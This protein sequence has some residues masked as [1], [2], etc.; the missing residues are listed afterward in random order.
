MPDV[1]TGSLQVDLKRRT[2][3]PGDILAAAG[4]TAG[5]PLVARVEEPG[6]IVLESPALLLALLQDDIAAALARPT[7]STAGE[8]DDSSADAAEGQ[9]N[10]QN[11]DGAGPT[12]DL[13][14]ELFAERAADTS[15]TAHHDDQQNQAS[16]AAR[17]S[18]DE[19]NRDRGR[20]SSD[21]SAAADTPD[22]SSG[23]LPHPRNGAA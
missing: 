10:G 15:L 19:D 5:S 2:T 11:E 7:N 14:A 8:G 21:G 4:I 12:R 6:R 13:V 9:L 3:L 17:E 22:E 16:E 20:N 1:V 23:D 18:P